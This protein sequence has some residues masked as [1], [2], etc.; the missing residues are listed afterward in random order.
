[1]RRD[2]AKLLDILL[3]CREMQEFVSGVSREGFLADRKLQRALCMDLEIVGEAAR[4]L[5]EEFRA[6]HEDI[7]WR[8]IIGLR[9][10]IAHE[11]FRLDLGILWEIVHRDVPLLIY[12]M[13]PLVPPEQQD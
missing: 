12:Q 1:M 3:A 9:H 4:A 7:P 2:D 11:Y 13:E 5:S 6:S 8:Q 10:K